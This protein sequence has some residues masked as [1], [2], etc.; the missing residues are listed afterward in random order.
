MDQI[1]E[2]FKSLT[3]F[4]SQGMES[5]SFVSFLV[6]MAFSLASALFISYLY[7]VFF[8]QR[9]TGS[10]TYKAF[11]LIGLSVTAIFITIQ[12]SLPLSL[13][14]LGALSIVR[15]RTPVK[16]P[17]EIGF[18]MLVIASSLSCA[19]FNLTFLGIILLTAIIALTIQ[20]FS[21]RLFNPEIKGGMLVA[22]I[23]GDGGR[24]S[25]RQLQERV[26]EN[27]P[28]CKIDSVVENDDE[29]VLTY[30]FTDIKAQ[31]MEALLADIRE[32]V[33]EAR[34]HVY[35]NNS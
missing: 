20:R 3:E 17:E 1:S 34:L 28:A 4:N 23:P 6:L 16:E 31:K 24:E 27:L 35:F 22:T 12:F 25:G 29:T 5:V 2:W 8:K 30:S 26:K 33:K 14:L 18:I 13:G 7:S 32:S 15:F 19:T 11:P 9:A 21:R 10:Q